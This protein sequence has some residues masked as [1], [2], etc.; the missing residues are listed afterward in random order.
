V[1]IIPAHKKY[2]PHGNTAGTCLWRS[3]LRNVQMF[4]SRPIIGHTPRKL[5]DSRPQSP[6]S[7]Q[8]ARFWAQNARKARFIIIKEIPLDV[9]RDFLLFLK[10]FQKF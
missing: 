9:K 10:F 2:R 4:L 7:S 1:R 6:G 3:D 8:F 5:P